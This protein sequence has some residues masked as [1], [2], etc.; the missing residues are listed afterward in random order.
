MT[1]NNWNVASPIDHTQMKDWPAYTR[2]IASSIKQIISKEHAI[3]GTSNAGGQHL[4]GSA[5]VYLDSTAPTTDPEGNN[6][7]TSVTDT[8][9]NGRISVLTGASN[10]LKVYVG[11][12]EGVSTGW[13]PVQVERVKLAETMDANNCAIANVSS[14]QGLST[15]TQSGY[16]LHVGQVDTGYFSGISTGLIAPKL[17]AGTSTYLAASGQD[18]IVVAS[19]RDAVLTFAKAASGSGF[20][21]FKTGTYTGN[22]ASSRGVTGIGF[23]PDAL[24]ILTLLNGEIGPIWKTTDMGA[25]A[26]FSNGAYIASV[27]DSL[28][29]DGFTTGSSYQFANY[30]GRDYVY[31]A[32]KAA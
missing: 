12:S 31:I 19:V 2:D 25:N 9:D 29:T 1:W 3:P 18:G 16:A 30:S 15:A 6:L 28:D 23:Q 10:T 8:S 14:V 20:A 32:I 26:V 4:K 24:V 17:F 7:Q 27:I 22:G 13:Q 21:R 5:R 11:T